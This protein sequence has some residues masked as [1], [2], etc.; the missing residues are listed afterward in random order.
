MLRTSKRKRKNK[1]QV[2]LKMSQN[3][4]ELK[5][6]ELNLVEM[7]FLLAAEQ[8]TKE[9]MEKKTVMKSRRKAM[10]PVEKM[11]LLI[12]K[13]KMTQRNHSRFLR[14]VKVMNKK[15]KTRYSRKINIKKWVQLKIQRIKMMEVAMFFELNFSNL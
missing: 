4:M 1:M 7:D 13:S 14:S 5:K 2:K 8:E 10:K 3:L 6:M 9:V 12:K 15:K 11:M